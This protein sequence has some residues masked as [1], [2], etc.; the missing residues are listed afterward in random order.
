MC[1]NQVY[2]YISAEN[3]KWKFKTGMIYIGINKHEISRK[4]SNKTHAEFLHRKLR[5][6]EELRKTKIRE[7]YTMFLGWKIQSCKD[8]NSQ[9]YHCI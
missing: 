4:K 1:K 5:Q 3:R 9:I 8:G 2:F 7:S 6:W